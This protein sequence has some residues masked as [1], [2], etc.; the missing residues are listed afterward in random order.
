MARPEVRVALIHHWLVCMGGAEKVLS[1]L[2]SLYPDADLFTNV[3]HPDA[4]SPAFLKHHVQTGFVDRLPGAKRHHQR[5]VSLMPLALGQFDL[6]QYDL[7]I[8]CE[9]GPAK[10]VITRPDALHICYSHSP[11]RYVWDMY[12]DYFEQA[13]L[14]TRLAMPL[15]VHRLRKWDVL[16]SHWV[17]HFVA[18]SRHSANRVMKY[19]RRSSDVIYP[20]V[21]IDFFHPGTEV[22]D[23]YLMVGRLVDYKRFDLA[24]DAFNRSGKKLVIIGQ[25]PMAGKL[26]KRAGPTVRLVGW[27]D[28]D[29]LRQYYAH[30]RALVFPGEE[31]FGIVPLEAM[32]SGR[33]VVAYAKGGALESVVEGA[34]GLFFTEQTPDGLA[35]AIVQFERQMPSFSPEVCVARARQFRTE[36]FKADF[37]ALVDRLLSERSAKIDEHQALERRRL[38]SLAI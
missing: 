13:S 25:G 16:S 26:A 34:T 38:M 24:I 37:S 28:A 27:Q 14:L 3:L 17:D 10:G 36:R 19:Y 9:A 8:S 12:P 33:P 20:P 30:C 7:V 5:Y 2:C 6:R 31:D 11:M 22:A 23:Y 35:D 21:D 4:V 15:L 32:A 1:A 29:R 18:N